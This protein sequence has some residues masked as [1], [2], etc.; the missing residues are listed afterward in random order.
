MRVCLVRGSTPITLGSV[1]T[2]ERRTFA[3]STALLGH[4]G[5][6]RLMADPLGSRQTFTSELIPAVAGD[7]VRWTLAPSLAL[8]R[9]S[10]RRA[11][12]RF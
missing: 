10:I 7:H 8:S 11:V 6:I 1:G 3:L 12:A 4:S 9:F 5:T 2:M